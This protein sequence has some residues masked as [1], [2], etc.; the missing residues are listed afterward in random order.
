MFERTRICLAASRAASAFDHLTTADKQWLFLA[1]DNSPFMDA[2]VMGL[3]TGDIRNPPA[4]AAYLLA[5]VVDAT[6]RQNDETSD[7][8]NLSARAVATM[9]MRDAGAS[10]EEEALEA[11]HELVLLHKQIADR[12]GAKW[13]LHAS[14]LETALELT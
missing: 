12:A 10:S 5:A 11:V 6:S 1:V 4:A 9:A 3:R 8:R 13:Q 14:C 2:A 7:H